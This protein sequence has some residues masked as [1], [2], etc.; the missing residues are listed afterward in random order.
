MMILTNCDRLIK[1][2]VQ[3]E[4]VSPVSIGYRAQWDGQPKLSVGMGGIK[5]NLRV[6][7]PAFGWASGDH[8]EPGVTI[9]GKDKP[10]PSDCALAHFACIGNEAKVV[11]SE[12]GK[13]V[14]GVFTGRHA[15]SDD[16]VWFSEDDIEKLAI[17]D[18]VQIKAYGVGLKIDGYDDVRV[19]KCSPRLL[20][21]MDIGEVNG[22]LVAPVVKEI[23][24]Y[25]MG[26]GVGF[27]RNTEP[28][29][30]DIQTNDPNAIKKY[31]LESLRLGD[32]VALKDQL[33]INGRGY[34]KGAITIGVIIHGASDY[35]GHGPGVN[36]L[37]S[38][39]E[40]RLVTKLAPDANTALY[41]G[42]RKSLT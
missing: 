28:V 35:A 19:N 17:G 37:L 6:G 38:T 29:D 15:G 27:S 18:K 11:T 34:Y 39:K 33:C 42:L 3:G 41:L 24:G 5:Y 30:Y 32:I 2:A 23:P 25:L 26:S 4:I 40:G 22:K 16:M 36:P 14:R 21:S 7:D 13:G 8:V 31:G 1:V 20:Q 12:E 9:R 10:I